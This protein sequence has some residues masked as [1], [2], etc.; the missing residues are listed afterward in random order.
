MT[1]RVL[2]TG[3]AS[4]GSP[5][6]HRGTS[7]E[8]II[9][10]HVSYLCHNM[11]VCCDG[12]DLVNHDSRNIPKLLDQRFSLPKEISAAVKKVIDETFEKYATT[13][14]ALYDNLP[15]RQPAVSSRE[16]DF[17]EFLHV[18]R[19]MQKLLA[20]ATHLKEGSAVLTTAQKEWMLSNVDGLSEQLK[21]R[22]NNATQSNSDG[23]DVILPQFY[24]LYCA[25]DINTLHTKIVDIAKLDVDF[26][27]DLYMILCRQM[28]FLVPELKQNVL[29]KDILT[30]FEL[31][32]VFRFK[33]GTYNI[34]NVFSDDFCKKCCD[35]INKIAA[36]QQEGVV[37]FVSGKNDIP[38]R[39]V[40]DLLEFDESHEQ[41]FRTQVKNPVIVAI[42][43]C[44][45][46]TDWRIGS[47]AINETIPGSVGQEEH[48]DYTKWRKYGPYF[49]EFPRGIL[50]FT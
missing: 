50:T 47:L 5:K 20:K 45:L 48:I 8:D 2:D 10:Q 4:G 32:E 1:K 9:K 12:P 26:Q 31:D 27:N 28:V 14:T 46:G 42:N 13:I 17:E 35:Q 7:N 19:K 44:T 16:Q 38:S 15:K 37:H 29:E 22:V 49:C 39:R 41:L 34:K 6:I 24:P 18:S 40:W 33:T 21:E 43:A 25:E 23:N 36:R 30:V 11:K 3:G